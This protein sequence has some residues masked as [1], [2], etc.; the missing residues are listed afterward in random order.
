MAWTLG[1][2]LVAV[3]HVHA[4]LYSV[5]LNDAPP[6]Y[7]PSP[8]PPLVSAGWGEG[9][10]GHPKN[11]PHPSPLPAYRER[12]QKEIPFPAI[13]LVCSGGH[14]ALYHLRDWLNIDL[15]GST[16]DDAVGEAYDK[17]AAILNLGYPG[18]PRIDALASAGNPKSIKFPRSLLGRDS[19]DFSFSGLKT[20]LL[21]HVRGFK[22]RQH[23]ARKLSPPELADICAA[24]QAACVDVLVEKIRRATRRFNARSVIVGG[25]V[26]ANS[27][28]RAALANFDRPVYFPPLQYCTDN[29]AMIAALGHQLLA[30][31]RTS[32]LDL[33][34]IT[35]SQFADAPR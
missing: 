21:Y 27:G 14:T 7:S 4:H 33:D 6:S 11:T 30:A 31:G 28:L 8:S 32:G 10:H 20:A 12:G 13:G 18:G 22:G 23:D 34:A 17:A 29:A 16:L 1:K 24:F 35:H 5:R 19:L 26:S 2:P 9:P 3:D 25:G 15:I